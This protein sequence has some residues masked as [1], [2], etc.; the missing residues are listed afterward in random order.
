MSAKITAEIAVDPA[1]IGQVFGCLGFMEAA[2]SLYPAGDVEGYFDW[3]DPKRVKFILTVGAED[4]PCTGNPFTAILEFLDGVTI[5]EMAPEGMIVEGSKTD[6]S[7]P[8]DGETEEDDDGSSIQT[9]EVS[10]AYPTPEVKYKKIKMMMPVRFGGGNR[11]VVTL[12]HWA[13]GS[14]RND[15]KL[16]SGNRSAAKIA[17]TM[18]HGRQDS[19]GVVLTKGLSQLLRDFPEEMAASPFDI[20]TPMGGSFN[21][22]PR[23]AWSALDLGFSPNDHKSHFV[24]ASP[25][26]E[27]LAIWGLEHARPSEIR[28]RGFSRARYAI[29]GDPLPLQ[30]ARAAISTDLCVSPSVRY[31]CQIKPSGNNKITTFAEKETSR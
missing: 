11:P 12:G 26:V 23:G 1:N 18:L 16:Y 22:D 30:L 6:E 3:R 17:R 29:W 25:I 21:L 19:K 24:M 14:S 20:L 15:F 13:D 28:E 27:F 4:S 31:A 2:E 9:L 8:G 10:S 7:P 5:T